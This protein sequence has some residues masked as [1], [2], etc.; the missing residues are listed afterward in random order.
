MENKAPV[1]APAQDAETKYDYVIIGVVLTLAIIA[2]GLT[3]LFC[4]YQS[5][6]FR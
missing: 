1:P 5:G 3:Y 2:G 6:D 4:L